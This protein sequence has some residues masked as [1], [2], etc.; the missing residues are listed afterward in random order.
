MHAL[1]PPSDGPARRDA[2]SASDLAIG[3]VRAA[4]ALGAPPACAALVASALGRRVQRASVSERAAATRRVLTAL[5]PFGDWTAASTFLRL[6]RTER[7]LDA[8]A[9]AAELE[10]FLGAL[11][12]GGYDLYG[13]V[14]LL[15][16]AQGLAEA[17]SNQEALRA[18]SLRAS[19]VEVGP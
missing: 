6:L 2:A 13:G 9:L 14:G 17:P 1:A 3:L 4:S 12:A 19:A 8:A 15:S 5:A 10:G 11:A 7:R 18:A 16:S